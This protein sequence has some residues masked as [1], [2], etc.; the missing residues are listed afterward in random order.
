MTYQKQTW[1]DYDDTK[2][3]QQ[4]RE[5]GAVITPERMNHI[6]TGISNSAD[7]IE[8]S[9]QLAQTEM[10]LGGAIYIKAFE[11]YIPNKVMYPDKYDWNWTDAYKQA[12]LYLHE[13]E[14]GELIFEQ[15][16]Y[17]MNRVYVELPL[18]NVKI[19]GEGDAELRFKLN[20]NER[21]MELSPFSDL[22]R[23]ITTSLNK[24]QK[25]ISL[26][27]VSGFKVGDLIKLSSTEIF[28]KSRND[29]TKGE[30]ALI[31]SV[32]VDNNKIKLTK[33][34][35]DSYSN[36]FNITLARLEKQENLSLENLSLITE[37]GSATSITKIDNVVN[38]NAEDVRV[39]GRELS[40]RGLWV[41]DSLNV[42][43]EKCHA[44][45]ITNG[46]GYGLYGGTV[47][48]ITFDKCTG[49]NCRHAIEVAG[50][51]SRFIDIKDSFGELC[52]SAV[53]STH[54]GT[55][56]VT[57]DSNTALNSYAGFIVR[58]NHK[59]IKNNKAINIESHGYTFGESFDSDDGFGAKNLK[60]NDNFGE[61]I[62]GHSVA[63][64]GII[65]HVRG[66]NNEFISSGAIYGRVKK[67]KDISFTDN[68]F[69]ESLLAFYFI[70]SEGLSSGVKLK[71][72]NLDGHDNST[73]GVFL[74]IE[75]DSSAIISDVDITANSIKGYKTAGV[76]FGRSGKSY[77]NFKFEGNNYEDNTVDVDI[78]YD[79][80]L[81]GKNIVSD[82]AKMA[83][84][85]WGDKA[86]LETV[87]NGT[88]SFRFTKNESEP[89]IQA[90][91]EGNYY[92]HLGAFNE[93]VDGVTIHVKNLDGSTAPAGVKVHAKMYVA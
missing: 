43:Y 12:L 91:P 80:Q 81:T 75:S 8:V 93:G 23:T 24:G 54:G 26:N 92:C 69:K 32:D 2:T 33:G 38:F 89:I 4:N 28:N 25:N 90:I 53:F 35:Y 49:Y 13:Q 46:V 39:N 70:V 63:F 11:E 31:E 14:G 42:N 37:S 45:N 72:N 47:E 15:G 67:L 85:T 3:E 29:Y 74:D 55:E 41:H 36:D 68:D 76:K 84:G 59:T 60:F 34:L 83:A 27:N 6:E 50:N 78:G 87:A 58:G 82:V 56:H 64:F 5:R 65:E 7:K 88:V 16:S 18:N 9:S 20:D 44:E 79:N 77:R 73:V 57:M 86:I 51:V 62:K 21:G 52:T 19:S 10:K 22:S 40:A 71:D 66:K 30:L 1:R 61:N 17:L 48:N